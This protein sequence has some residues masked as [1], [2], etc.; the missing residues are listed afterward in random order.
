MSQSIVIDEIHVHVNAPRGLPETVANPMVRTLQQSRFL[1]QLRAAVRE[2]FRRYPEL[3]K[4]RV[5]I[6][7]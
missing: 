4:A 6:A 1:L 7:R 2:V 3:R 5:V